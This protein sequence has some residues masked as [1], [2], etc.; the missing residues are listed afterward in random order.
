MDTIAAL[1][2]GS[3]SSHYHDL[4]YQNIDFGFYKV[5]DD[6]QQ[7][8]VVIYIDAKSKIWLLSSYRAVVDCKSLGKTMI[9]TG[10]DNAK[11]FNEVNNL[12]WSDSFEI[13]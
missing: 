12:L 4:T 5:S 8:A 9:F 3:V 1:A 10:G 11:M 7:K 6:I 2:G 13:F